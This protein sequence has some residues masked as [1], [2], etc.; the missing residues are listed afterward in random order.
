MFSNLTV[1]SCLSDDL[2]TK[3]QKSKSHG[4]SLLFSY[5]IYKR[6][7]ERQR[8]RKSKCRLEERKKKGKEKDKFEARLEAQK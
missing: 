6:D 4:L 2:K 8:N 5:F 3:I 7:I 1:G